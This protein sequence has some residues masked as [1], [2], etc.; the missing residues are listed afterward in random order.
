MVTIA[1]IYSLFTAGAFDSN[2][3]FNLLISLFAAERVHY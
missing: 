2:S 1:E 3:V